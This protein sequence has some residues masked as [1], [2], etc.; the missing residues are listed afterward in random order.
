[1]RSG[2]PRSAP[3][4]EGASGASASPAPFSRQAYTDRSLAE[5][6][7]REL[8]RLAGSVGRP[9]RIMEVCG[10]HTVAIRRAG[11]PSL[12]PDNLQ[13]ISGPGCPVC[14]TPTGY[15]DNALALL[16][17]PEVLLASFGDML[18]VPGSDGDSLSRHTGGGRVRVLYSPAELPALAAQHE[19]PVVFLAI[20]FETTIPTIAAALLAAERQGQDNLYLYTAFK[21]VPPALRALLSGGNLAL[22]AFLLPGHVSVIL[23]EEPYRFLEEPGGVPGVITGFE[24]LDILDGILAALRQVAASSHRVEN[25]YTRAV[26]PEGNPRARRVT[27][28]VLEPAEAL[29]RGLGVIPWSGMKLR[30]PF[31]RRDA[32]LRFELPPMTNCEP[33]GCSCARVLQGLAE[34]RQ[35]PLFGGACTPERPVGPCMVSSEGSCAAEYRYGESRG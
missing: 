4:P 3:P 2:E 5:P 22:D 17:R 20:G 15:I 21:T 13:L 30:K 1:M 18:K 11:I 25:R 8:R 24:P 26:R 29:W 6:V 28:T 35:C 19:G 7:L 14:V 33:P 9:V 34:P 16:R 31:E 12:L 32:A 27:D 10:T 23:G